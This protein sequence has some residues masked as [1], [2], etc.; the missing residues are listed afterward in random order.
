MT[1][2]TDVQAVKGLIDGWVEAVNTNDRERI[3]SL[4]AE[5]ELDGPW[6]HALCGS[7]VHQILTGVRS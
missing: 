5:A 6:F 2:E 1:T 4:V 7:A 3:L